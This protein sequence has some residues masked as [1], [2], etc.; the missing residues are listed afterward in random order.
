MYIYKLCR[1][2]RIQLTTVKGQAE[3]ISSKPESFSKQ[4]FNQISQLMSNKFLI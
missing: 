3:D 1:K 2:Y 4:D